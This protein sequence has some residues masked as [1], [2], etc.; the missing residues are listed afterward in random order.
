[1]VVD[2]AVYILVEDEVGA[3]KV[4][5]VNGIGREACCSTRSFT[6]DERYV[7]IML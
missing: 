7:S 6:M 3:R 1:M 2:V 4:S 5:W